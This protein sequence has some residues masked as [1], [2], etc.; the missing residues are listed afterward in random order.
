MKGSAVDSPITYVCML[1][2]WVSTRVM[3]CFI[4]SCQTVFCLNTFS[5]H[6]FLEFS[7]QPSDEGISSP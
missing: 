1:F 5:L 6:L 7:R 2:C 3:L 4:R